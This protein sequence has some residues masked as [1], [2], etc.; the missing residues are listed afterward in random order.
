[1]PLATIAAEWYRVFF[2]I[3]ALPFIIAMQGYI[4]MVCGQTIKG[5]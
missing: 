1:M 3:I 5:I 4:I 2:S